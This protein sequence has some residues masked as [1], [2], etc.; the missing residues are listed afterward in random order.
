MK[1]LSTYADIN[2][3]ISQDPMPAEDTIDEASLQTLVSFG[4]PEDVSR[5]ALKASVRISF[6]VTSFEWM[7]MFILIIIC[8]KI[9]D[10]NIGLLLESWRLPICISSSHFPLYS[11]CVVYY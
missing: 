2:E 8:T 9:I 10:S 1:L 6:M 11:F 4:F 5:M 3:P 7:I